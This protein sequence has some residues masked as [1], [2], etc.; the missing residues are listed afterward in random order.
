MLFHLLPLTLLV[1]LVALLKPAG[2]QQP[3]PTYVQGL[4]N[5]LQSVG[6]TQLAN[7]T[8]A[9]NSTFVGQRLLSRLSDGNYTVFAPNDE[10]CE[11]LIIIVSSL[12]LKVRD[13]P[14]PT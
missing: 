8:M 10:A 6:L 7:A 5:A 9:I 2:A 13:S 1:S 4:V 3:D 12:T 11:F 14:T